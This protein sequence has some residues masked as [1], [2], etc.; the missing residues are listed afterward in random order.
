M[1]AIMVM[2]DLLGGV[3]GK[4]RIMPATARLRSVRAKYSP[5]VQ[6]RSG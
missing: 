5:P 6:V 1:R 3:G 2:F 4:Q